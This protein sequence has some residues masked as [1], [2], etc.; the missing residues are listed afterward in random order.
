MKIQTLFHRAERPL[1][2]AVALLSTAFAVILLGAAWFQPAH[3]ETGMRAHPHSAV[4][5]EPSHSH[6]Q[7]CIVTGLV[8]MIERAI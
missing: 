6:I 5:N 7:L 8:Q 4:V 3:T 2:V 1:R